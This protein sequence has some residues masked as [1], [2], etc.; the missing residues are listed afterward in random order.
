LA[1]SFL[2][3]NPHLTWGLLTNFEVLF[4]MALTIM[5]ATGVL[6]VVK[7]DGRV[8][9]VV[10][11]WASALYIIFSDARHSTDRKKIA[12]GIAFGV[13]ALLMVIPSFYFGTFPD[14]NVRNVNPSLSN[15]VGISFS[16][17]L[18][19]VDKTRLTSFFCFGKN[20]FTA[21]KKPGCHVNLKSRLTGERVTTGELR[22]R[23]G[24]RRTGI[25][26]L[27]PVQCSANVYI[28]PTETEAP[29][30]TYS[31]ARR[32]TQCTRL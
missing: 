27:A 5:A 30:Y 24:D 17:V 29:S 18:F 1:T 12:A 28:V 25:G 21:A 9:C 15:D 3:S 20:L 14:L 6:G 19:I 26:D 8:G 22:K 4:L 16:N 7:L 32:V 11:W 10:L 2:L 23:L 31:T 13:I